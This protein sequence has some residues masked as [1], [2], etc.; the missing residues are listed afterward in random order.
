MAHVPVPG[1][2][3]AARAAAR[4]LARGRARPPSSTV[5][6][7]GCGR[8]PTAS[9]TAACDDRQP[10]IARRS[11]AI[12]SDSRDRPAARRA[13]RR[14][15]H[16]DPQPARFAQLARRRRSRRRCGSRRRG[17]RRPVL[18]AVVLTGAGRAFCVGQDL[19]EHVASPG[20]GRR[21]PLDTVREHYNP[22]ACARRLPKPVIAAVRGRPPAPGPRWRCWPTSGS[23]GR[24]PAFLMAFAN[25][26]W[27]PTPAPRGRC[28][29]SSATPRPSSC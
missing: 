9:S 3:A 5:T 1:S 8:P 23:A 20:V 2:A 4:A 10:A 22:I 11:R 25:V 16:V 26:G 29:A 28:P 27:P 6:R 14:R 18:R 12:R 7:P 19:R 15:R 17:E 24:R 13:R 21:D